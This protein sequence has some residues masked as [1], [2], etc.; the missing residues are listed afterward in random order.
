MKLEQIIEVGVLWGDLN[1]VDTHFTNIGIKDEIG[2]IH[3]K[4]AFMALANVAD[5]EPS[6]R[7]SYKE[8]PEPSV[9]IKP[10]KKQLEFCKYLRN[11]IVG[12]IHPMLLSKAIEWQPML[13]KSPGNLRDPKYLL[14][15]NIWLLET[16]INTYVDS[17]GK[18]KIFDSE[19]DLMYPPDWKRF[20]MVLEETIRGILEYLKVLLDIWSPK[21]ATSDA[22]GFDMELAIKA[23][24]TEFKYLTK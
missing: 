24:R 14:I 10:L 1:T 15:V 18:H 9:I 22:E 12:H 21:L 8:H 4:S 20:L 19:T 2:F 11:K 23:G 3:L 5:M 17:E 16:A 6:I 7:S 13:T